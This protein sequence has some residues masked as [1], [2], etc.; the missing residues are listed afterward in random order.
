MD[1]KPLSVNSD[2]F[3]TETFPEIIGFCAKD[4]HTH[5]QTGE[6]ESYEY[7]LNGKK[8]Y[9]LKKKTHRWE[10]VEFSGEQIIRVS[11]NAVLGIV[12]SQALTYVHA[13][14]DKQEFR[15]SI[16]IPINKTDIEKALA[17]MYYL[18]GYP[19]NFLTVTPEMQLIMDR[20]LAPELT[21]LSYSYVPIQYLPWLNEELKK[22]GL[23]GQNTTRTILMYKK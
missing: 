1:T 12:I 3:S 6:G 16:L 23:I 20:F 8:T 7:K 21:F 13:E 10:M 5:V 17:V 19:T 2:Y 15:V 4:P 11:T 9:L 18:G 22:S 14:N